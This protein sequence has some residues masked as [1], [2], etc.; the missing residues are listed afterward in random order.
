MTKIKKG[1]G[2]IAKHLQTLIL[3]KSQI[4]NLQGKEK[5]LHSPTYFCC[6]ILQFLD[7]YIN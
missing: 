5:G 1:F 3:T 2:P 4:F 7:T 6:K